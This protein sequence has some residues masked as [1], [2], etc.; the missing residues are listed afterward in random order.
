MQHA[1]T[2]VQAALD[3]FRQQCPG[4]SPEDIAGLMG[5]LEMLM[6]DCSQSNIQAPPPIGPPPAAPL[7]PETPKER[8]V[9]TVEMRAGAMVTKV[10]VKLSVPTIVAPPSQAVEEALVE[11]YESMS[12]VDKENE[13]PPSDGWT[14]GYLDKYLAQVDQ[15]KVEAARTR[16]RSRR[17]V[18]VL[19]V[20]DQSLDVHLGHG[21]A[22]GLDQEVAV[23]RG[24]GTE[25]A[26]VV[27]VV[28]EAWI[29]CMEDSIL[30]RT[31]SLALAASL[32]RQEGLAFIHH[33]HSRR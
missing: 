20:Q 17:P 15:A 13:A 26:V 16:G 11:F 19:Y 31:T 8:T 2:A 10:N 21:R 32:L 24:V 28:V 7:I 5:S 14:A 12:G 33:Q 25:T 3:A 18:E 9:R 22:H 1:Q 4:L 6:Q 30:C 29:V 27:V 23:V